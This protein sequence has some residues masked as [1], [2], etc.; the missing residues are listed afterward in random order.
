MPLSSP[1]LLH[2]RS[3][4]GYAML[5]ALVLIAVLTIIGA[6][7]LSVAGVDQRISMHNQ[8]HMIIVNAADAGTQHARYQ[9]EHQ[10]PEDEG[11]LDSADTGGYFITP[12]AAGDGG[13]AMFAGTEFPMNQGVYRVE[14]IFVKCSGPPAGYSTEA[15]RQTYRSDYWEMRSKGWFRPKS[16]ADDYGEN[17]TNPMEATVSATIRKVVQGPCKIR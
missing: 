1:L 9:L 10:L 15:G 11:W 5:I 7:T 13:E 2:R 12:D 8:R 3:Q 14:A 6:T 17:Q 4:Q 16:D